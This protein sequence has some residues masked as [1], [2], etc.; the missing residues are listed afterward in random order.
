MVH[1]HTLVNYR[2]RHLQTIYITPIREF[3]RSEPIL[4]VLLTS[5]RVISHSVMPLPWELVSE[6]LVSSHK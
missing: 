5:T 2:V 3:I 6:I 1:V 4:E